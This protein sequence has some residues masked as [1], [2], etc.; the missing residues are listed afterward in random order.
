MNPKTGLGFGNHP[1]RRFQSI[2]KK[3]T[4]ERQRDGGV[5][6][7]NTVSATFCAVNEVTL[8]KVGPA[9]WWE[10]VRRISEESLD[11]HSV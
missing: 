6:P 2:R 4:A 1:V 7:R 9:W 11:C 5:T 8:V 3:Y 10:A